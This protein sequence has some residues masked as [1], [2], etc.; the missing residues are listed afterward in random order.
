MILVRRDLSCVRRPGLARRVARVRRG[1][2]PPAPRGAGRPARRRCGRRP[3]RRRRAYSRE[4]IETG[5]TRFAAQCG[6]C[7]GR[8]AAGG[9]GGT[10]L[11][12]SALVGRGRAR[13]QDRSAP[14]QRP[15]RQGHAGLH[16]VGR[17]SHGH[18]RLHPRPAGRSGGGHRRPARGGPR[19][20]ADR[21]RRR[22]GSATSTAACARCHSPAGDLKGVATRYEGLPLLQRMLYPGS[23]GRGAGPA[24]TPPAGA[25]HAARRAGGD[26]HAGLSRRVHHR[27]HR[28]RRLA[29][30]VAGEPGHATPWTIGCRRTSSSW[31]NTPMRTCTMC[32]RICR[33][34]GSAVRRRAFRPA[35]QA[36]LQP[37]LA[38]AARRAGGGA[39]RRSVG[40]AEAAGRQLAHVPRRLLGPSP[41]PPH[42][43][44]ARQRRPARARVGVPDRADAADQGHADRGQRRDLRHHARQ[45][46]GDRRAQRAA[47]LALHL[48]DERR[49][50]HRA[51]R[52]RRLQGSGVPDHAGRAPHRARRPRRHGEVGRGDRRREEGLL[53]HQRAAPHPQPSHRRRLGR[54][55]QPARHPALVR[56]R[57][58]HAAVDVLQHAAAGH[59]RLGERRRHRRPDVDDRHLR[60]G[61]R[62][63]SS[64]AP[65]TRRRCSTARRGPATTAGPA[66]SSRSIPTP[67]R[68][69][70]ASRPRRTTPTTGTPP[71][72]RCSSTPSSGGCRGSCCCRRR[73]TA[74]TSCSTAPPA[75]TC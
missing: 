74:T 22:R 63:C 19:R 16:A 52:R 37:A 58:R 26:R 75:R 18:R 70:G 36:R 39:E 21:Q 55:R 68:W 45:P 50:P 44:H 10:D 43:D 57:H 54:L 12:R 32:W 69:R 2:R 28:R 6:F 20:S 8:D 49:L 41:Q 7:H 23:G 25:R 24:P 67:A 59:A 4:Q 64:S 42:A 38:T 48:P 66:R 61:A 35:S 14:A 30:L 9:E 56:R 47:D 5:R 72:C 27:D 17:R 31:G 15:S 65:A 40:A 3:P 34:C 13:R 53:V 73:A 62:I 60:P 29:A 51:P 71:K 11:T 1:A 33:R 46:L